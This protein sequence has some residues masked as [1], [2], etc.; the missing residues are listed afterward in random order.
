M[1]QLTHRV[2]LLVRLA[3]QVQPDRLAQVDIH[4][5]NSTNYRKNL[6]VLRVP[7]VPQVPQVPVLQG[8]RVHQ[9]PLPDLLHPQDLLYH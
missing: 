5:C 8:H 1:D 4:F 9:G 7:R 6:P 3:Q 2:D